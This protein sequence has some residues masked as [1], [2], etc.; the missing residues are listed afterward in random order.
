MELTIEQALQ[1]AF[2]AHKE[3]KLEDAE[4]L[5]RAILQSHPLHPDANHNL[6]VLAVSANKADAALP[7]FKFALEANP[8]I[9]Q[10]WLSYI[11][12]LIKEKQ[13]EKAKEVLEQAKKRGVAGEKLNTLE[14]QL[15]LTTQVNEPKSSAQKKGLKFS[16]KRKKLAENKKKKKRG[17]QNFK[18]IN[19]PE[20]EINNL[21]QHYQTGR[22]GDAEKLALSITKRFPHH[23]FSWKVLAEIY[24]T[25]GR[26]PEALVAGQKAVEIDP[27]DAEAHSNLGVTQQEVGKLEEAK[28][29][30][31]KAIAL[32]PDFALAH[33]NLGVTLREMGRLEEAESSYM[34]AIALESDFADAY[35]NLGVILRELGRLEESEA[36]HTKAIALKPDYTEAHNNLGVIL[37]ELAKLE[38]AEVSYLKAIALKPDF[39]EAH[40]N[41]GVTLRELGR[42][43][44]AQESHKKAIQLKPDLEDAWVN[45]YYPL[46]IIKSYKNSEKKYLDLIANDVA[47]QTT[48]IKLS[49]LKYRLS[50]GGPSAKSLFHEALNIMPSDAN[51][52]IKNPEKANNMLAATHLL[53][54]KIF[55]LL[56]FGRAGTGL[57]HSLVDNHSEISTLPSIY[58]SEFF[59][60]STWDKI[61]AG[62]WNEMANRFISMYPV[63]FDARA[64][65][66]IRSIGGRYIANLGQKEGMTNVGEN[67]DEFI[68]V[69][70]YH[71][72]EEL[73][74]L[75]AYYDHLNAL[76]FFKL[77]H[78]A[79]EKTLNNSEKKATIFYH[80]HN[81]GVYAQLNFTRSAP[82]TKLLMMVREPLQSCE[83]WAREKFIENKHENIVNQITTMLF[84]IDNIIFQNKSS[85]GVRLEDLK[86]YP[87]ETISKLCDWMGIQEE[88]S[89]YKMT[90]QGKK[91]WGDMS[92]PDLK[93]DHMTPFGKSSI[94][95]KLGSVF[96]E[97]DQFILKTLFYPFSVRFGY[98]EENLDQFK[99]DLHKIRP[100][101]DT[102]LG[103]EEKII[104]EKKLDPE[105]FMKSPS[106]LY[107]RSRMIERWSVLNE[108]H[109]YPN[110]L[111]LLKIEK[112]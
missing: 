19:P 11:D 44:E 92:S 68:S 21:L 109:T 48:P 108:F 65:D 54:E 79:Y 62:G 67:R 12:A 84:A 103:F 111:K 3:G 64:P 76:N 29:S 28:S 90:A 33:Y 53:P 15:P 2:A 18:K 8:K 6:G 36:S 25:I 13:F 49:V 87:K 23:N 43:E 80:I 71:F 57:L 61:I 60:H 22:Y 105:Q 34:K 38:D 93:K 86:N 17:K 97:K 66:P 42:L 63:L 9:E 30:Y 85:V 14:T 27:Q 102:V 56:S 39:A 69:N 52:I 50:M 89:L 95:R 94:Q 100:M 35:N 72:R 98:A 104:T 110:M 47:F 55:A 77:V 7:L 81:P 58:F 31:T 5:Y 20:A 70:K 32:E 59:D 75:M 112:C 83:S 26:I 78:L 106:Y 91:W 16:E 4:R 74:S 51:L 101:I 96:T 107:L 88:E 82:E 1:Q 24:K 46:Q 41:L 40:N 37:N 73:T 45:I 10:F 99:D